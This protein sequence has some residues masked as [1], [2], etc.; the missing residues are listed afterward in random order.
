MPRCIMSCSLI[1]WIFRRIMTPRYKRMLFISS[2]YAVF[3][4][5]YHPSKEFLQ[6]FNDILQL[7]HTP[8]ALEFPMMI[9]I[10]LWHRLI[11]DP[12]MTLGGRQV[13]LIDYWKNTYLSFSS[14][15]LIADDL[16]TR[17]PKWMVYDNSTN[18]AKDLQICHRYR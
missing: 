5:M 8:N 13:N 7:A 10:H 18:I 11:T 14:Y 6:K 4:N 9:A 17:C 2:V 3:T 12:Y 16:I 15:L 1:D